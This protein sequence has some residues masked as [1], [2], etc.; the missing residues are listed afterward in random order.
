M[1]IRIE[2]TFFVSAFVL[3]CTAA[4]SLVPG[5][6]LARSPRP[7][8]VSILGDMVMAEPGEDPHLKIDPEVRVEPIE[9]LGTSP[10][11]AADPCGRDL[12]GRS[13]EPCARMRSSRVYSKFLAMLRIFLGTT[14]PR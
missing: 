3:L 7:G 13:A 8:A 10:P 12:L 2:R 1:R 9:R 14:V 4:L 6:C 11:P 5:T